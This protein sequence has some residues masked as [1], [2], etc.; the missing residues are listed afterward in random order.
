VHK[1]HQF[2]QFLV[3]LLLQEAVFIL[4]GTN[5]VSSSLLFVPFSP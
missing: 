4:A 3:I 2:I 1:F 5:L